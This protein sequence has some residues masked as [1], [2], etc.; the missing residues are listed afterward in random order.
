MYYFECETGKMLHTYILNFFIFFK[1]SLG[2]FITSF[3]YFHVLISRCFNSQD[4]LVFPSSES[5]R[6]FNHLKTSVMTFK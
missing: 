6:F 4:V 3:R 1:T 5:V 2:C